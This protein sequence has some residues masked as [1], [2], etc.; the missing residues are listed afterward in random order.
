MSESMKSLDMPLVEER[1]GRSLIASVGTHLGVACLFVFSSFWFRP[2]VLQLGSGPGGGTGGETYTVGI[3]D[4]LAGGMGMTKPSLTPQPPALAAEDR[5]QEKS[6][7]DVVPLPGTIDPKKKQE[8]PGNAILASRS[9]AVPPANVI[10]TA[11]QPGAGGT[12]GVTGGSGGGRGGGSGVMIGSGSGTGGD[13]WYARVVEARISSNWIRPAE[14]VK[15]DVA[16]SFFI[17]SDGSIYDIKMDRSSGN[18]ELDLTAER[19]IRASNPL[20][21]PPPG[22]SGRPLQFIAEFVFP[23]NR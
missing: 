7:D 18:V 9:A 16:F 8:S 2:A 1:Y 6:R 17:S 21:Q 10:P 5:A 4:E 11:P 14:G 15:V 12:G 3:A 22:L 19:A 20:A 13:S 23:P